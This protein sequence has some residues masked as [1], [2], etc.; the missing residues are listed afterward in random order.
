MDDAAEDQHR[1]VERNPVWQELEKG[2][3]PD[4]ALCQT[5]EHTW[6]ALF[7]ESGC[8]A[9]WECEGCGKTDRE[10]EQLSERLDWFNGPTK[11]PRLVARGPTP[12]VSVRKWATAEGAILM[13]GDPSSIHFE[14]QEIPGLGEAHTYAK[15][16]KNEE[17]EQVYEPSMEK[18]WQYVEHYWLTR[19]QVVDTTLVQFRSHCYEES[20]FDTPFADEPKREVVL[21]ELRLL[22]D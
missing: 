3:K 9:Y 8:L 11:S 16:D 21:S 12:P 14:G 15:Y 10:I 20:T 17:I 18:P 22:S 6:V 4:Q 19:Y 13:E 1:H 5:E 2:H 7:F